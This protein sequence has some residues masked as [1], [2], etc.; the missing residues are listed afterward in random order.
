MI[1][2][3]PMLSNIIKDIFLSND[4][5]FLWIM[6]I[7]KFGRKYDSA[8]HM[9]TPSSLVFRTYFPISCIKENEFCLKCICLK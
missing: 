4:N 9:Q 5:D 8:K 7:R 2:K 3:Y 1:Y 6:L